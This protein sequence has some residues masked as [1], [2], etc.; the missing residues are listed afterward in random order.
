MF[1]RLPI[2][3]SLIPCLAA[4][5]FVPDGALAEACSGNNLVPQTQFCLV[6]TT[7]VG[8]GGVAVFKNKDQSLSVAPGETIG[9]WRVTEIQS[10]RVII[11][12]AGMRRQL[13]MNRV[14]IAARAARNATPARQLHDISPI[15]AGKA[16]SVGT[17]G[18]GQKLSISTHLPPVED[19]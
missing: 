8:S 5:L 9:N 18:P 14:S 13:D 7:T 16:K 1:R 19:Y 10:G 4:I 15:A 17:S 11:E 12:R 3:A 2:T 6:G